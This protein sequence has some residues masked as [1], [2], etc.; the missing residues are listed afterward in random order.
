MSDIRLIRPVAQKV[1][2]TS[3]YGRRWIF[4]GLQFHTG[5]DFGCPVGAPVVA[6][7]DGIINYQGWRDAKGYGLQVVLKHGDDLYTQYGHLSQVLVR[8]GQVVKQGELIAYSGNTGRGTGAHLHFEVRTGPSA[9][10][11]TNPD[12][13]WVQA[14]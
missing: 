7:A 1:R 6:A 9:K 2:V 5:I 10:Q 14:A 8:E 11:H 13:Y 12:P 4:G 3:P